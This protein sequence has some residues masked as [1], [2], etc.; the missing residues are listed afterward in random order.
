[1]T[2]SHKNLV[3]LSLGAAMACGG[4]TGPPVAPAPAT[5]EATI[6]QFLTAVNA[7]DL[8]RMGELWGTERGPSTITLPATQRQ[9][10]LTIMQRILQSDGHRIAGSDSTASAPNRRVISVNLVKGTRRVTV[11]FTL[12]VTRAGGWLISQVALEAALPPA[13]APPTP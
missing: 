4:H 8:G 13:S 1:M 2:F 9:R 6:E 12:V 3:I 5:P 7:G 10:R 11:P